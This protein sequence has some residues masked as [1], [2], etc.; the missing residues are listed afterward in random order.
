MGCPKQSFAKWAANLEGHYSQKKKKVEHSGPE[1]SKNKENIPEHAPAECL[2]MAT[3]LV[4]QTPNQT[5]QTH[6]VR[7]SAHT[8]FWKFTDL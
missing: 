8:L 2:H 1:G 6:R 5:C 7:T 3:A 4:H